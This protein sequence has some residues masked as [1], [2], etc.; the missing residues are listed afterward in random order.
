MEKNHQK[1]L[2]S[3]LNDNSFN[4]WAVK[5][6]KNDIRFWNQWVLD[7]PEAIETVDLAKSI[8]L[9]IPFEEKEIDPH[10]VDHAL[11]K[12]LN[13]I[14][15]RKTEPTKR[16]SFGPKKIF[17][18]LGIAATVLIL[19]GCLFFL[20]R[21]TEVIHKTG[22]GEI[23]EL[24]LQDGTLVT[25]NG[26]S[27]ISYDKK[28]SRD[29]TLKG[30]A[31]FKV[32]PIPAT[33]TKFWVNTEDLRVEVYGTQ[34]HVNTR[35]EKTNVLLDEGSVH[36]LLENGGFMKMAP[37]EFVSFA[38]EQNTL[39]HEKVDSTL[40]YS[41]W[42]ESTYIFNNIGLKEVMKYVEQTY[43]IPFEF[44]DKELTKKTISGGIPNHDLNICLSAIEKSTGTRIVLKDKK[45]LIIKEN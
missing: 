43:G 23:I 2:E 14:E 17:W 44:I 10:K 16:V 19:I 1:L 22:Y 30:D 11:Q 26:N 5:N 32:K 18:Q 40:P 39:T 12:V 7:H 6:N 28:N 27:Q 37:G 13:S 3:L 8:I 38:K 33:N 29:I 20:T 25:L 9:G 36:L 34:F 35:D 15:N 4:N 31:Y 41:T 42:K 24:K 21:N 45:L